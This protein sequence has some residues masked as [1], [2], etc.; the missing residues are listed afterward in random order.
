MELATPTAS[1]LRHVLVVGS[2]GRSRRRIVASLRSHGYHVSEG[3]DG[4]E[5]ANVTAESPADLVILDV[6]LPG[7]DGRE[8]LLA[9]HR[10]AHLASTMTVILSP[11]VDGDTHDIYPPAV[12]VVYR[13]YDDEELVAV[14]EHV[15]S[16]KPIESKVASNVNLF[17]SRRGEI[18][19]PM[20]APVAGSPRWIE[21]A[22]AAVPSQI[23]SHRIPYQ[24]QHCSGSSPLQHRY[25][26]GG[27]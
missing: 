20:H 10:S 3:C 13:P 11:I 8:F 26:Q 19:C 7:T 12:F 18:A 23:D 14:V 2:D 27:R 4:A 25:G 1:S 9:Q 6:M 5:A 16:P 17:W 24:C 21:E 15:C 22:W